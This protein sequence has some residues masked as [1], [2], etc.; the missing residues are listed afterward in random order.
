MLKREAVYQELLKRIG[1]GV[2]KPGDKLPSARALA[3]ELGVS[4]LRSFGPSFAD[5][6][7]CYGA[8]TAMLTHGVRVPEDVRVA[9][10]A[11]KGH[12]R[13]FKTPLTRIE[14]DAEAIGDA[15]ADVLLEYLR[16]GE[17]PQYRVLGSAYR[18]GGSFR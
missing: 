11:N 14:Y 12:L 5:D 17:F 2:W 18:I 7:L 4:T 9:S 15:A 3:S 8:M 16:N 10:V 13:A 6:F 1:S